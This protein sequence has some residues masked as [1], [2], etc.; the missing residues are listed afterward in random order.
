MQAFYHWQS[1]NAARA[2]TAGGPQGWF[3]SHLDSP[4]TITVTVAIA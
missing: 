2:A 1:V 3:E 4:A